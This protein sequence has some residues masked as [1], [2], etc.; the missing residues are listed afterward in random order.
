MSVLRTRV[1]K[2]VR[3]LCLLLEGVWERR[4]DDHESSSASF[5]NSTRFLLSSLKHCEGDWIVY[6]DLRSELRAGELLD[7]W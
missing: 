5:V 7:T 1:W 3:V 6:I 2:S 4:A